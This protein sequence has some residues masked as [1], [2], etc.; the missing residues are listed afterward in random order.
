LPQ[1]ITI[2]LDYHRMNSKS[3]TTSNYELVRS[4]LSSLSLHPSA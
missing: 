2:F 4:R 3:G 1:A